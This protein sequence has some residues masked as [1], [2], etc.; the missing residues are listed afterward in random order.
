MSPI[1]TAIII[2]AGPAGLTAAYELLTRTRIKP[3]ILEQS[4]GVGGISRTVTFKHNRL[5]IGGHRFFTQSGRVNQWWFQFLPPEKFAG[6]LTYHGQQSSINSFPSVSP[7]KTNQVMLVRLRRS[8]I[9]YQG[10]LFPYPLQITLQTL[11]NLGFVKLT[12]ILTTFSLAKL[13]PLPED[14]LEAFFKNRFGSELYHTFFK[15]YT[16]KVWGVPCRELS[17]DWGRQR[18]QG[19][20]VSRALHFALLRFYAKTTH[21][22]PR[23]LENTLAQYFLY[24]RLGPGQLWEI[25]AAKVVKLG[26]QILFNHQVTGINHS[27]HQV[28]SVVITDKSGKPQ[29]LNCDYCFSTMPIKFLVQGLDPQPPNSIVEIASTLPY[30]DFLV[31]GLLVKTPKPFPKDQWIYLHDP[32]VKAGRLQI[33]NNWSPWLV[34]NKHTLWLGLEY[35]C[36]HTDPFW[37]QTDQQIIQAAQ[38]DLTQTHLFPHFTFLDATVVRQK[39]AYPTYT[40]SYQYFDKIVGYLN[41][42]DNLYPIGRN[43]MHRYNNQDHSIL[44]AL[45]A[46]DNIV[47]HT[48]DKSNLWSINTV[49]THHESIQEN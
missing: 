12:R 27:G 17:A 33:F 45:T 30:R 41:R 35:F 26:G 7:R 32:G 10:R 16:E 46:V 28:I 40:G 25:V 22:Q 29:T 18:I 4:S 20:S 19:M 23:L 9:L 44:T 48:Q 13:H 24:P 39:K 3:I 42:F 1:K 21:T 31:V 43:G 2:G 15:T 34:K 5:D 36:N 37:L 49:D 8:R 14:H 6:T 47:N 38:K 11:N